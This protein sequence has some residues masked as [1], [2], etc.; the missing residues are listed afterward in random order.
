MIELEI[1]PPNPETL[2]KV[3]R[4]H[5]LAGRVF[6]TGAFAVSAPSPCVIVLTLPTRTL[7]LAGRVV[8][9][10]AEE[11]HRGVGVHLE[12]LAPADREELSAFVRGE[13]VLSSVSSCVHDP[14]AE[15]GGASAAESSAPETSSPERESLTPPPAE[16]PLDSM[17]DADALHVRMRGLSGPE[18]RRVALTGSLAERVMLERLYGPNV[19][20]PLLAS[21]RLSS[22]EIATIARKGNLP[23]P[24][25]E[26]IAGNAAWLASGEVQRALLSNPRSS[27]AVIMKVLRALSKHDL[28]RVPIQTA[29]PAAVRQAAKEMLKKS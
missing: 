12:P 25:V 22:P 3:L 28:Q 26:A 20:E 10:R 15:G 19:W 9:V 13:H 5:V 6:L 23:R 18:Q 17:G 14:V 29:Y 21:G 4:D 1:A 11:P 16:E 2:R 24:L 8:L 7:R 27:P